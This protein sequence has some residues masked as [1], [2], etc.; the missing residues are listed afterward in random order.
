MAKKM[1]VGGCEGQHPTANMYA[2]INMFIAGQAEY[3]LNLVWAPG[4][5]FGDKV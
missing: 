1:A 4:G 3:F 2:L 5:A